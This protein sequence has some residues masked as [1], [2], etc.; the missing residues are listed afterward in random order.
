MEHIFFPILLNEFLSPGFLEGV[1]EK[2]HYGETLKAEFQAVAEEM[3]PLMRRDAFWERGKCSLQSRNLS[4]QTAGAPQDFDA[5]EE[6]V[7]MSLGEGLDN[8]QESYHVKGL[9]SQSYMLEVLADELLMK[10]Y[11][12]YNRYIDVNTG[13]HVARYRFPGSEKEFPL[14]KIPKLLEGMTKRITCNAAFCM[15][16]KKSVVFIARLTTDE[17]IR[18][19]GVCAGCGN[20]HCVNRIADDKAARRLIEKMTDLPLHYGYRRIFGN[21]RLDI[22]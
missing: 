11:E 19:E 3:L 1:R 18:C 21:L 22:K 16:P 4:E 8:L 13:Q 9:L 5:S 7:I 2:F 14:E 6:L 20:L 12:A 10:A 15:S 17:D